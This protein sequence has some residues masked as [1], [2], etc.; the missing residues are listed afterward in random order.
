MSLRK[1][2]LYTFLMTLLLFF[3][4]GCESAE[5][6]LARSTKLAFKGMEL[7][8]WQGDD[9]AWSFAI[10]IGTNRIKTAEEVIANPLDIE[11]VKEGLCR[12]APG[13]QVF[14]IDWELNFS[15]GETLDLGQPPQDIIDELLDHTADCGVEVFVSL[16]SGY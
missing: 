6:K 2:I 4:V 9:G 5:V 3:L 1:Y 12:L 11:E 8:S 13:E 16:E 15:N 10:L 7:Y 14:W